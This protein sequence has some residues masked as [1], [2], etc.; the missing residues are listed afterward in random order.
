[1]PGPKIARAKPAAAALMLWEL[2][3]RLPAKQRRFVLAQVRQ[4]GPKA[5]KRAFRA[6]RR[7]P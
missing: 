5:A 2:W 7:K 6:A 1:M 4:H 3:W